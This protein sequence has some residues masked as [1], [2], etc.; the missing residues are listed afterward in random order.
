MYNKTVAALGR[1]HQ[2]DPD[3]L[4]ASTVLIE[5]RAFYG[6]LAASFAQ[7]QELAQRHPRRA[8]VHLVFSA[9]LRAAG[10]LE[11]AARECETTHQL[12]P[13]FPTGHC[14]VLYLQMGDLA[15][16]RQEIDRSPGEFSSFILG[17]VLLREGK[18]EEALPTLKL[19]PAGMEYEIIRDC[20]PDPTTPKCAETAKESVASFLATPFTNAWYFGAATQS[21]VRK[22]EGA[23]RLLR[24]ASERGFCVYPS[25]DHERLFDNIRGSA[26]FK[27][28]RQEGIACQEKFAPYARMQIQ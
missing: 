19:V 16:A 2:L 8:E 24:A 21:F 9:V 22:K 23:I 6:D 13:E 7:I 11:Q 10:A 3:L 5:T 14:Y 26:E 12:D 1:A 18:V 25:V 17:Q 28:V 4:F 15:K 27:A 20:W